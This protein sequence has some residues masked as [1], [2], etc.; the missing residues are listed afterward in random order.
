MINLI[1]PV[2][3][4][5][6]FKE[7]WVRAVSVF[8]SIASAVAL[9]SIVFLLPVYV[10][11]SFQVDVYA[12]SANKVAS[13][14]AEYDISASA[15]VNANSMAQKIVE[16]R[17]VDNF[18]AAAELM[19]SLQ[20]TGIMLEGFEFGR[21]KNGHLTPVQV[22]GEALTRQALADFRDTLLAQSSIAEVNLPISNL[23]KDKNIQFSLSVS[24]KKSE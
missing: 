24:F 8:L 3:R 16:L 15:L 19:E 21:D 7:Y 17:E 12:Q 11:I 22:T 4:K 1:P 23:A 13:R 6:I 10:L 14:V 5:A 9:V 20:G 2:V 18:L